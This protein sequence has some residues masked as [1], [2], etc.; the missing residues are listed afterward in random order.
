MKYTHVP[1]RPES[2]VG[3]GKNMIFMLRRFTGQ[4]MSY[5]I[6]Q[7]ASGSQCGTGC[8]PGRIYIR[9]KAKPWPP[10]NSE[11]SQNQKGA[12]SPAAAKR[13]YFYE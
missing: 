1:G 5:E 6:I 2:E 9:G 7:K 10:G 4:E 8:G 11:R 13:I 12:A 3:E